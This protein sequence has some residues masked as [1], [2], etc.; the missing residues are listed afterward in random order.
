MD[1]GEKNKLGVINRF[2]LT[3]RT[4]INK[5]CIAYKTERFIP[6]IEKLVDNY[7]N[8]YHSTLKTTPNN[9]INEAERINTLYTS[10]YLK[11]AKTLPEYKVGDQARHVVDLDHFEKGSL[12]RYSKDVFSIIEKKGNLYKLSDN[13]WYK[14]YHLSP[15]NEVVKEV[16]NKH[17]A[18]TR[19]NEENNSSQ[20]KTK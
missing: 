6:I 5:Y 4:L 12:S 17:N 20:E 14:Y 10:K 7:N 18:P 13:K 15:I 16:Q 2:C 19:S 3:I 11:I 1:V 8:T 9:A